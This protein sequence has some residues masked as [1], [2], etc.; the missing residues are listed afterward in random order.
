MLVVVRDR[1]AKLVKAGKSQ[2]DVIAAR[3]TK[4]FEEKVWRRYLQRRAVD[5]PRLRR[6]ESR[7]REAAAQ[8]TRRAFLQTPSK[9]SGRAVF[10][11]T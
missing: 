6:S 2:D 10:G 5:R 8:V 7:A 4:E 1:I 9:R 11:A 3:P